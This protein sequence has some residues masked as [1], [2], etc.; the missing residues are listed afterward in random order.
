MHAILSI[1]LKAGSLRFFYD[2]INA[3]RAVSLCRLSILRQID[4]DRNTAVAQREM[5]GLVLF[6]IGI[7][8]ENG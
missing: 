3:C 4:L 2:L 6:M 1:D 8:E 7:G 5:A